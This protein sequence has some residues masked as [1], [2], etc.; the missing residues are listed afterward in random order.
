MEGRITELLQNQR[1]MVQRLES[2]DG[3][4]ETME[5][6]YGSL[7]EAKRL[8]RKKGVERTKRWRAKKRAAHLSTFDTAPARGWISLIWRDPAFVERMQH[9]TFTLTF[10]TKLATTLVA[11]TAFWVIA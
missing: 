10:A 6:I 2:I 7:T 11:R 3:R 8:E 1:T 4:L 9:V 5:K